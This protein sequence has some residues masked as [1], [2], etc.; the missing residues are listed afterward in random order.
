MKI[1][2]AIPA[3]LKENKNLVSVHQIKR[4]YAV[5]IA[6]NEIDKVEVF[7]TFVL[8]FLRNEYQGKRLF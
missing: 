7:D 3:L 1:V 8:I 2:R 4:N 6:R 5:W